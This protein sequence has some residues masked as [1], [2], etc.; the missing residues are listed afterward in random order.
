[1]AVL[2]TDTAS[3]YHRL[4]RLLMTMILVLLAGCAGNPPLDVRDTS[5]AE[6]DLSIDRVL[7]I[8]RAKEALGTPYRYGGNTARG[9]DCSG[10]TQISYAAAG[11]SIPRTSQQQFDRLPHRDVARPGDLL[12]FGSGSVSHVGV[13]IGDNRMIHAP[14]SGRTVRVSNITKRYW[15]EHY[16]GTA[17]PAP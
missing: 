1:M 16:R 13:Y 6:Q 5:G 14:G 7:I 2:A 9:M 15:R 17:G 10:L 3:G 12:F 11:I 8:N 4:Y